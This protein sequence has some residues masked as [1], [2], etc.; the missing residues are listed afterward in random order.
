VGEI[1]FRPRLSSLAW[2]AS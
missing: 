1:T 2:A